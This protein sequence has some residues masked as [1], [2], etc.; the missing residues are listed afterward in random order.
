M[1]TVSGTAWRERALELYP[2]G[3]SEAFARFFHSMLS[4]GV[5]LPPSQFETWFVSAA[6]T[7][8]VIDATLN[9]ATR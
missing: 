7:R 3:V 9:A 1:T 8:S 6:H 2:G 5:V 4:A